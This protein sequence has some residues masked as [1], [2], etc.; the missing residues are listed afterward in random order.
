MDEPTLGEIGR[1]V[2]DIKAEL[3][4]LRLELVRRDVY[5]ANRQTDELKVRAIEADL[6]QIQ[7][8]RTAMRRLLYAS[9][10]TGV[11]SIGVWVITTVGQFH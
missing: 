7:D 5:D 2:A 10:A 3:R 9:L 8:D 11:I 1:G 6:K 4:S